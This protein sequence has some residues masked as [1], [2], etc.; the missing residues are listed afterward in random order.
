MG[1]VE[2]RTPRSTPLRDVL[3]R[4]VAE[5][6]DDAMIVTWDRAVGAVVPFT[7][8][9]A[10]VERV[11]EKEREKSRHPVPEETTIR[12]LVDEA[13]WFA[14]NPEG[15]R[16]GVRGEPARRPGRGLRDHAEEVRGV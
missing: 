4:M 9:L 10:L 12:E 2:D 11:L 7:S 3:H 6:G 16:S 15:M 1:E 8:D 14:T 5:P 13:A